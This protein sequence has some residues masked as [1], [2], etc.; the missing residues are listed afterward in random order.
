MLLQ[1]SLSI[2]CLSQ[3][4]D[5]YDAIQLS[6]D[7]QRWQRIAGRRYSWTRAVV[8]AILQV[9]TRAES[10]GTPHRGLNLPGLGALNDLRAPAALQ[11]ARQ[12]HHAARSAAGIVLRR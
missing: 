11:E 10:L 6:S 5:A 7:A 3:A 1:V 9:A 12:Q 2:P 8:N 4:R